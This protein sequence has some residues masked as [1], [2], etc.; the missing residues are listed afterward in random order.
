MDGLELLR[1]LRQ[2]ANLPVIFLTSK[3][4]EFDEALGLNLA[5]LHRQTLLAAPAG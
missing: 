2:S 1:R 4:D 3:D 5:R